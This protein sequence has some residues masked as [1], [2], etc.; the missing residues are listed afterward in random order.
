MAKAYRSCA[1]LTS[2]DLSFV[3][4][5]AEAVTGLQLLV[6]HSFYILHVECRT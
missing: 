6:I 5:A 2:K 4:F 3:E 1:A